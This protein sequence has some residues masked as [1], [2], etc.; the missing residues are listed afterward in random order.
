MSG[1]T[2]PW[3]ANGSIYVNGLFAIMRVRSERTVYSGHLGSVNGMVQSQSRQFRDAP[4]K[5]GAAPIVL[6]RLPDI[7]FPELEGNNYKSWITAMAHTHK[8]WRLHA[9]NDLRYDDVETPVSA[10]DGVVV[11]IEAGM[12]LS[13]TGKVLS[14]S[15]PYS[16]PPLPFVPGTNAIARVIAVGEN[17]THVRSGDPVFL[18]PHLRGDVPNPEP[19]QILIGL[20]ATVTT[21]AALALQAR[22][23]DGVFAEIAH[24][25][26]A[27][28]TPLVGLSDKPAT[29]LIGLAKLIVPFGGLQRSE[30]RGGDIIIVNGAT[31]Y[32]GS[33]AVMLAVAM[34]AGRVV[35]V[36]R[37]IAA[38]K[39]LRAAFG[40]RVI[41]AAV[42]GGDA[43]KDLAIIRDA[44]GGA[45]D[46]ALDL[47]GSAKST[48]TTLSTLRALKRGGRL[49]IMGSAEVPLE[50]SF[51]EMLANDWEIVGKFMYE[52]QAPGQLA[53]LAASGLLDLAKIRVKT[54]KLT[55]LKQAIEAAA[56]MQG[57]D[58][59]A[60]VP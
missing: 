24:W 44:A 10:P 1:S 15:V 16:L 12:V 58:L 48:S 5:S 52:R 35:A 31:G 6:T 53:A 14:G 45:A 56:S 21:P 33:G 11:R 40:P 3:E 57:L 43:A 7:Y 36:G 19:P 51:R 18:S 37:N 17:V 47:L 30:L 32:F 39:S 60:V 23:R 4:K 42:T 49:V 27:C 29:E 26:S 8:A 50:V 55:E 46:V 59:T 25:P 9:H 34:G 2:S 20:T 22:W 54:F 13:Y 28:V 38:L 41:A